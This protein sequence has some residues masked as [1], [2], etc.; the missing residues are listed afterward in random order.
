M[1][2]SFLDLGF[3]FKSNFL[4]F[5]QVFI[6]KTYVFSQLCQFG[7]DIWVKLAD[8]NFYKI[9]ISKMSLKQ[10][11]LQELNKKAQKINV[12]RVSRYKKINRMLHY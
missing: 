6:N 5:H 1:N 8:K 10:P 9:S 7:K 3:S 11:N 2:A 4:L 12:K